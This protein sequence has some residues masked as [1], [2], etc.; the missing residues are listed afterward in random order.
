MLVARTG[1]SC[2][3]PT[4]PSE[5]GSSFTS[6]PESTQPAGIS[7]DQ[8]LLFVCGENQID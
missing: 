3:S 5:Q 4:F 7:Q 1:P 2:R 8:L 6:A